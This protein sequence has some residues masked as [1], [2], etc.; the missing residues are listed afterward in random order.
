MLLYP[1]V[2]QL[3]FHFMSVGDGSFRS[4]L[5]LNFTWF[6]TQQLILFSQFSCKYIR[7]L[8]WPVIL[9]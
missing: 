7:Y 4:E 3:T 6:Y 2:D 8:Y 9:V 1:R 5:G